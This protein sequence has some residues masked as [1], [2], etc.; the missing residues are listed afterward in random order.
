MLEACLIS[1]VMELDITLREFL[2][3]GF[4]IC[5]CKTSYKIYVNKS[6]LTF[7]YMVFHDEQGFRTY[8]QQKEGST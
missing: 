1:Y 4:C 3:L 2:V 8:E 7:S 6:D 5:T